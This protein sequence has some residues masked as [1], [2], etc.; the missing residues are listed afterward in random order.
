MRIVAA[1]NL[2]KADSNEGQLIEAAASLGRLHALGQQ[3][4]LRVGRASFEFR[5]QSLY[6]PKVAF[7][8]DRS[9]L[10]GLNIRTT[11][12]NNELY[13]RRGLSATESVHV[14]IWYKAIAQEETACTYS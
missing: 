4:H 9:Y 5:V 7:S 1:T 8:I 11:P 13:P 12:P 10:L 2:Y 14:R 6:P 3:I